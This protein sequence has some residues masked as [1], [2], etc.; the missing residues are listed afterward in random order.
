MEKRVLLAIFLSFLVLYV[1]QAVLVKPSPDQKRGG[2]T[3]A[4]Q[5]AAPATP[6]PSAGALP[7][8]ETARPEP[9]SEPA[10]RAL[11][12]DPADREIVVETAAVRA[13]FTNRGAELKSWKLKRYF[14]DK[15]QPPEPAAG[16]MEDFFRYIQKQFWTKEKEPQELVPARVPEGQARPFR[17]ATDDAA[18]SQ[19]LTDALFAVTS[20]VAGNTVD[21]T[22]GP[23]TLTFAF[24]DE[25]GLQARKTFA[26]EPDSYVIRFTGSVSAGEKELNPTVLWGPGIGDALDVVGASSYLQKPQAIYYK[27]GK[28]V[29]VA[30]NK[31]ASQPVVNGEF[32]YAGVDDH[33]FLAVALPSGT[34]RVDD[35]RYQAVS[36]PPVA[37]PAGPSD[38]VAYGARFS[39]PPTDAKFFFGPKDFDVLAAVD[40]ELV[41][42][43][44]YGIFSFL[45]VPLLRALKGINAYVGNYGW[46][47]I[48]LTFLINAAMFPLR[49]KSVVSMR[50]M[51][52]I[53]PE[54]KAIQERYGKLKATDPERQKMNTEVMALY[55]E[56]GVNPASGCVPMLLTIPVLFAFYALLSQ[57]IEIRGAPF[58]LWIKDLSIH[59]T[60]YVTP[61]LMGITMVWQQKITPSSADPM[62]QKM[63]MAM[64][65]VFTF[66]FL[67]APSGLVIYWFVSNVMAIAQQYVTNRIVGP[68]RVALAHPPAERRLRKAG[69]GQA[70]GG[71]KG[72]K[73]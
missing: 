50:R 5:S 37:A 59:D 31:I 43:I 3:A 64:P 30:A 6:A 20:A 22:K 49:H 61:I 41:R 46:S 33:Y 38:L 32:R 67:W 12:A 27:D 17:L 71:A 48:I 40:R 65:L 60:L 44:N 25:S 70:G 24:K 55:K 39:N 23:A 42:V 21:G 16:G 35:V 57:A 58:A 7:P 9:P 18:V 15:P 26:F 53:Q 72:S 54:I 11:V 66:M 13:V 19:R 2:S 14:A 68:P 4:S 29:R 8:A 52:E 69:A 34:A 47:I 28:V 73:A 1:Y 63:M 36:I 62:Q 56:K 45:A 51:Q 10:A